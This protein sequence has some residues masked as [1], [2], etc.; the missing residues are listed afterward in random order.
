MKALRT[1]AVLATDS[2]F[3]KFDRNICISNLALKPRRYHEKLAPMK[4]VQHA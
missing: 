1:V 3:F 4:L 2:V